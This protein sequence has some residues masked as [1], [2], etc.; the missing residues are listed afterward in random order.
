M[1]AT[2]NRARIPLPDKVVAID[3]ALSRAGLPHAFGGALALAYYAEPRAT[4]DVD[5]N[6]FVEPTAAA[7]VEAALSPLGVTPNPDR[8]AL[9]RGG[10]A[11]WR[12]EQTP[13]DL[14]FKN[15]PI[16]EAMAKWTRRVPFGEIQIPI[17]SPEHLLLCKVAFDRPKDWL[18]IEQMLLLTPEIDV[19]E[20]EQWLERL[21]DTGDPR[22]P[23][24][25]ALLD[26]ASPGE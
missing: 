18:D 25:T 16:H 7:R 21:L 4:I 13:I 23:R 3:G 20:I 24:L 22:R 11:R 15:A 9:E 1:S 17:L 12:W 14:F 6:V 26:R 5:V 8:A 2:G 19:D 10:Q